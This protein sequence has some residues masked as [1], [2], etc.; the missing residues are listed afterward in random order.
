MVSS[1]DLFLERVRK[2]T[3]VKTQVELGKVLGI[4]QSSISDAKRRGSVPA[5]WLMK[6]F[7]TYGLNPD[8]LLEGASPVY[9]KPGA[10]PSKGLEDEA[11]AGQ[12]SSSRLVGVSSMLGR[13]DESGQWQP[14][15][16][17]HMEIPAMFH[18]PTVHVMQVDSVDMAPIILK[19]AFV[20]I[21]TMRRNIVDGEIYAFHIP[22]E[23]LIIKRVFH[24]MHSASYRL[25]SM[26]P[27]FSETTLTQALKEQRCVGRVVWVMQEL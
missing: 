24:D 5:D 23:G 22:R 13:E 19:G 3:G 8:W 27:R 6:L 2:A 16:T 18:R 14:E 20:G 10:T 4:R 15:W 12:P 11:G 25:A 7:R 21:D 9:L 1:F 17:F 26:D